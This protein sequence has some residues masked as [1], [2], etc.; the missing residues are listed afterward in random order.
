MASIFSLI[1]YASALRRLGVVENCTNKKRTGSG[2]ECHLR[3]PSGIIYVVYN[4][5]QTF[6]Y[7]CPQ[8]ANMK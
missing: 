7:S 3:A 4:L 8:S 1:L 5:V 6:K 2:D